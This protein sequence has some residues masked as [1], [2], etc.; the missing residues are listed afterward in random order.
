MALTGCPRHRRDGDEDRH[1]RFLDVLLHHCSR[2]FRAL[3]PGVVAGG[4]KTFDRCAG[5]LQQFSGQ[6]A[7]IASIANS[8]QES[9]TSARRVFE[10]S[11]GLRVVTC[12]ATLVEV[13][14]YL[15]CRGLDADPREASQDTYLIGRIDDAGE[16]GGKRTPYDPQ[17]GICASTCGITAMAFCTPLSFPKR[18][19]ARMIFA[20]ALIRNCSRKRESAGAGEKSAKHA[21]S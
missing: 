8:I 2:R 9:L 3:P 19:S 20:S 12:E 4:Q 18:A 14:Q 1:V 21:S 15:Q 16:G 13:R 7:N 5:L 11:P 6:V 17:A 10:G